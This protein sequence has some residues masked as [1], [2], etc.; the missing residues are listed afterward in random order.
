[1][2]P[3][4]SQPNSGKKKT[5]NLK[6]TQIESHCDKDDDAEIEVK[7]RNKVENSYEYIDNAGR[8]REEDIA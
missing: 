4:K 2:I 7:I 8:Y 1:M 3:I 6:H 5:A